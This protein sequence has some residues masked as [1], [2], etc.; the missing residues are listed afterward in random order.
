MQRKR[1]IGSIAAACAAAALTAGIAEGSGTTQ[2]SSTQ[3]SSASTTSGPPGHGGP[4][5]MLGADG[6][7]DGQAVHSV[8]VVLDKAKTAFVTQTSDRGTIESVDA[9][10]GTIEIAEGAKSIT[11]KTATVTVPSGA[12]VSL[13]GKSSTLSALV[14]GDRVSVSS[15]SDGTTVMA[16]DSSFRPEGG[17]G[18]GGAKGQMPPGEGSSSGASSSSGTSSSSATTGTTT[19]G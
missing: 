16:M 19:S 2:D 6:G 11:Y 17:P 3:T 1:L 8:S 13:D 4:G 9:G 18:Q 7:A 15:S 5:G 10:A 12:T 14:K